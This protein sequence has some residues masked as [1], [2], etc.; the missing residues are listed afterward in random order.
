MGDEGLVELVVLDEFLHFVVAEAPDGQVKV[1]H[2]D[3]G[4]DVVRAVAAGK[5]TGRAVLA[6]QVLHVGEEGHAFLVA[7]LPPVRKGPAEQGVG[8][9]RVGRKLEH[10]VSDARRHD[11]WPRR[12]VRVRVLRRVDA[13]AREVAKA[14]GGR[15]PFHVGIVSTVKGHFVVNMTSEDKGKVVLRGGLN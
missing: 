4:K 9:R 10:V 7:L 8:G 15:G 5:G 11:P 14:A 12:G 6:G 2:G 3:A 13:D 1:E